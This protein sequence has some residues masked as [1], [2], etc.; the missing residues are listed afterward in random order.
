VPLKI[1][2]YVPATRS[3]PSCASLSALGIERA[4]GRP[5]ARCTRSPRAEKVSACAL[6]TGTVG[7]TPAFPARWFYALYA[8]SPGTG[9]SCPCRQR[10]IRRLSLSVGRPGPHDFSVRECLGRLAQELRPRSRGHRIP[11]SRVVTIAIRPSANEAGWPD[12][13]SDFRESSSTNFC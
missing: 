4:Q 13:T 10:I 9:L 1:R 2:T 6:T 5:S 3:R 7:I 8:L 12:H 11:A